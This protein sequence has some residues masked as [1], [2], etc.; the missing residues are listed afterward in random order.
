MI[1]EIPLNGGLITQV[2]AEE[3]GINGCTELIN[4]ELDKPG[5]IYKRTGRGAAVTVAANINH[6]SK[7]V[8]GG[9]A[10]WVLTLTDGKIHIATSLGSL[11][12]ELYDATG[13]DI[14]ILNYGTRLRFA[15]GL[16]DESKVYQYIDRDF[17]W[18]AYSPTAAWD[19]STARPTIFADGS[20]G[21][22]LFDAGR[23]GTY[24]SP[25][26]DYNTNRYTPWDDSESGF[27]YTNDAWFYKISKVYDGNQEGPLTVDPVVSTNST[28]TQESK[29]T[30]IQ[31]AALTDDDFFGMAIKVVEADFDKRIT[32]F[33]IYR[34]AKNS[35]S[36]PY[37]KVDAVSTLGTGEAS[38][39]SDSTVRR[40]TDARHITHGGPIFDQIPDATGVWEKEQKH[41]SVSQTS[42]S[43]S[44]T[45]VQATIWS[46]DH[47]DHPWG[48]Y[49][50]PYVEITNVGSGYAANDTIV[51]TD[52]GS[53]SY[54]TTVKVRNASM[55]SDGLF[56]LW[57]ATI[58]PEVGHYLWHD[59]TTSTTHFPTGVCLIGIVS[60]IVSSDGF[61][62]LVRCDTISNQIYSSLWITKGMNIKNSGGTTLGTALFVSNWESEAHVALG[63]AG[64]SHL[65]SAQ[66]EVAAG[67]LIGF[68]G[69]D[70]TASTEL[71][72]TAN[73]GVLIHV[74]RSIPKVA[75]INGRIRAYTS[76][77]NAEEGLIHRNYS[78]LDKGAYHLLV[79]ADRQ[80]D[81]AQHPY[82]DVSVNTKFKYSVNLEGRQYV[83]NVKIADTK[84]ATEDHP[85]W[86]L[87]SELQQPDVIPITNYISIPDIQGGEIVGLAK[88]MGDLVVFQEKG[89]YRLSVPGAS[90]STWTLAESE[91]H[92]GCVSP[93][94]IVESENGVFF[95][96]RDHL[97]YLDSNFKATPIT[98]TIRDTYQ[99]SSNLQN[100]RLHI[101][102]KKER[103]LC[104]FGDT[105][106]TTYSL[107]LKS[108]PGRELWS[109][110]DNSTSKNAHLWVT[111]ENFKTHTVE[112]GSTSY[113]C[114]LEPSSESETTTFKRTTGWIKLGDLGDRYLLRMLSLRYT[115]TDVLTVKFYI[116][117]D[118][119]TV[120]QTMTIPA[121]TSGA[122][123]YRCKPGV[124]GRLCK[125]E[126]STTA[127][128]NDVEI[129]RLEMEYE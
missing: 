57:E 91:P 118:D 114:E 33:N 78:W 121:D 108:F 96:G 48:T 55:A 82:S 59:G 83:A 29:L 16:S 120:V 36:G 100:T 40:V 105:V 107:D 34:S 101:D 45:G 122:D 49:N 128:T 26:Y 104:R 41:T 7:W 44:G 94:S 24:Y 116:D 90:P 56:Y 31:T 47:A 76:Y 71:S 51:F 38:K 21:L 74:A 15:T 98:Q 43:G 10:Y 17:F 30:P 39:L 25:D 109:K 72:N 60:E 46:E 75:Y 106:A 111:D 126:I 20:D 115:S 18:S 99:A 119:S 13:T 80:T 88:L 53:T 42:T 77:N 11:D 70:Q 2:D 69:N 50:D 63:G 97:Y 19:T 27:T 22:S 62:Y 87:F 127:S 61:G 65:H 110:M 102:V 123:W 89:I 58:P 84:G 79:W 95:A 92:L 124:R 73:D 35:P 66:W 81:G 52:P 64:N 37:Y 68:G 9:T 85:D 5:L 12:T 112:A 28:S 14:R 4:V 54:T 6:I 23:L 1:Q 129:R 93:N 86:V 103:L 113:L 125:I 117:G 8:Y 67:D 3:I 32:G